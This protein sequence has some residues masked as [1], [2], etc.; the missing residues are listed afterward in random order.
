MDCLYCHGFS[1]GSTWFSHNLAES[2][3]LWEMDY[4]FGRNGE[5]KRQRINIG[6]RTSET[7]WTYGLNAMSTHY[8]LVVAKPFISVLYKE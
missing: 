4:D 5:G 7:L 3:E 2:L 8:L 6:C 1:C